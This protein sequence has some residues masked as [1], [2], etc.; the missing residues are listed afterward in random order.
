MRWRLPFW[1]AASCGAGRRSP[2]VYP[3]V[4]ILK[5]L[6]LGEPGLSENLESFFAQDYPGAVQI[7]FG[8]HDE[9]DPAIAV[10][11]A[12]QARYPASR[13]RASSP[14]ARCMAPTPRSPT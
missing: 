13:H 1:L 14:T 11:K 12:L 3:P 9:K 2:S 4:T 5:P 6:H 8:V 7:V 10:V